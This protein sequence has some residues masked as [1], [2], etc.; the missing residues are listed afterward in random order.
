MFL[1][2]NEMTFVIPII[3][4]MYVLQHDQRHTSKT[5]SQSTL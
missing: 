2:G 4:K 1:M 5:R 3:E